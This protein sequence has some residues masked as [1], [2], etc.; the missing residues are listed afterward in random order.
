MADAF[1]DRSEAGRLLAAAL[2]P[3]QLANPVVTALPRRDVP[4]AAEVARP[5]RFHAVGVHDRD[6]HQVD[7][8]EVRTA[9][10]STA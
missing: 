2:A 9:L 10:A 4:V 6:F 3:L 1:A 5:L 7:D 8:E